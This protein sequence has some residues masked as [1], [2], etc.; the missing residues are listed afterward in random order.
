MRTWRPGFI[1]D[2]PKQLAGAIRAE[3]Q[4]LHKAANASEPFLAVEELH[5]APKKVY[6][7]QIALADGSDWNPG[8]GA[9]LYLYQGGWSKVRN[10]VSFD[11][12]GAAGDG[13]TDDTA[14]IQAA[15]DSGSKLILG[16]P[17]KTY[18]TTG[19]LVVNTS[20]I[21]IDLQGATIVL[22]DATGLKNIFHLGDGVTKRNVIK[23][24]NGVIVRTQAGTAGAAIAMNYVG[25][26][27]ICGLRIYGNSTVYNAIAISRGMIVNIHHNYFDNHLN[28]GVYLVGTGTGDDRSVDVTL[29]DN[30]IEGGVSTL[31]TH[32]FV[33]GVFV[34]QN[35]FYNTSGTAVVINASSDANGGASFKFQLNDFDTCGGSGLYLDKVSNI[36]VTGNWFSSNG[37]TDIQVKEDVVGYV[38]S[39]N[40]MYPSAHAMDLFAADGRINGNLISGGTTCIN[41]NAAAQRTAITGNTLSNA[42]YAINM[43]SAD[44]TQFT[45]NDIYNMSSGGITG[46]N[47]TDC[48]IEANR[49]DSDRGGSAFITVGA[50]PYTY[51]AG[52][53]PEMVSIYGGTVSDIA[54]G[55]NNV[56][57]A[58]GMAVYLPPNESVVVTYTVAPFMVKVLQ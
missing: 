1:S 42:S 6:T 52:A 57:L 22:D 2:D 54:V 8:A 26:V 40:Q 47:G 9:G 32:D 45:A 15:I 7:G 13:S 55:G 4:A 43:G 10:G 53:R 46:S 35:I 29:S 58:T 11:D 5:A 25:V 56:A 17:G 12:K 21:E 30:R 33:E 27:E 37:A 14:E 41:L 18:R 34:R 38:I 51:T 20:N 16:S 48:V 44:E 24:H 49:G 23:L 28:Y 50:S 3:L 31:A 19:Q 39:G 36:Q